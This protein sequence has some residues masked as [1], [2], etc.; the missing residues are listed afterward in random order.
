[1]RDPSHMEHVER[2]ARYVRD[3]PRSDWIKEVKPLVDSQIIMASRFYERLS[4]QPG[5][6]EKIR[7]LRGI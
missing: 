5:G 6:K 4:R 2:W 1:M 3:H 7:K